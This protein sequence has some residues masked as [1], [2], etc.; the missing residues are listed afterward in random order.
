M[1]IETFCVLI[2][3]YNEE[4]HIERVVRLSK[5]QG[6][7]E[8]VVV[9][10]GSKDRTAERAEKAG[11]RVVRNDGNLGKGESLRRGFEFVRGF[12]C[13]AVIV[14][15]GDGQHNPR[16]IPRFLDAY[17][18]TRIP[19]LVGNRM[20][21]TR[22]MPIVRRETNRLMAWVLNRLVKIYVP[23]PPCGYRLYRSD[24]LPFIL[25]EEIRFAFE[26]DVLIHAAVRRI[27]VDSV[28]ISTI[29]N[30]GSRSHVSPLLD[31]WLLFRVVWRNFRLNEREKQSEYRG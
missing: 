24:V 16:E 18:R 28:R 7:C 27:R 20:A 21:N 9:D 12:N 6:P 26:F 2:C 25:S 22:G 15:D 1:S 17:E 31:A 19:V 10:D 5:K 14:L 4:K 30:S 13:S 8:V 3:A 23:D 29:Y 11:A